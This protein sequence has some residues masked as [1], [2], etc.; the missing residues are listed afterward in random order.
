MVEELLPCQ[1]GLCLMQ[2]LTV[3]RVIFEFAFDKELL[4]VFHSRFGLYVNWPKCRL[5]NDT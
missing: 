1:A 5:Q 4:S 3:K 2:R